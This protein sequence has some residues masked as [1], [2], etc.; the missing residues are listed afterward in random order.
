MISS[1][2]IRAARGFL[3]WSRADLA[4]RAKV[5]AGTIKNI[6]DSAVQ[7]HAETMDSIERVFR[8]NNIEFLSN[9]GI[10]PRDDTV[11]VITDNE[12]YLR[13]LEDV[14]D[15]LKDENKPEAL[16]CFVRN[17]L[18]P[19]AVIA[20]EV[21]LRRIGVRFRSLIEE[22]DSYRL[23]PA[24]EYRYLPHRFFHNNAQVIYGDKFATMILDPETGKDKAA[25]IVANSHIAAVQRKLFNALWESS[26]K[27]V[28][29]S[30]ARETYE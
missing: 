5:N 14:F 15:T 12:P 20:S 26:S 2:Q 4:T 25:I 28:G 7:P 8:T 22:G 9:G 17:E 6:E 23:Y 29:K 16:F 13:I 10:C 21:R 24:K 18:C 27:P 1:Q 11:R 30:T 19:S 3:D